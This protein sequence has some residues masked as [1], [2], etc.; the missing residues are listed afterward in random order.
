MK[1]A[2][3]LRKSRDEENEGKEKVLERHEKQLVD[4]C[5]RNNHIVLDVFKEVVSGDTIDKRPG[6][7]KLLRNVST[8]LYEGVV[9]MDIDRLS[10]GSQIDQ[11]E[12]LE[13]FKKSGTKILTLNKVYDLKNEDIDEEFFEF[14]LFMSRREYKI[15]KK[16]MQRG[17]KQALKD[18]YFTGGICPLGYDKKK[19]GR[20]FVLVP[21]KDAETVKE[22]FRR[23]LEG[24]KL[25]SIARHLNN[26]GIRSYMDKEFSGYMVKNILTNK[27]YAGFIRSKKDNIYYTGKHAPIISLE[28]YE[29]AQ[30]MLSATTS[31][32]NAFKGLVNPLAGVL[33]C[34]ICG[35]VMQVAS[36]GN[37]YY[38]CKTIDCPTTGASVEKVE[39]ALLSELKEELASFNYYVDNYET[40]SED[41]KEAAE[42]E[43]KKLISE[44][45]K[46][47]AMAN[48]ACELLEQGIYT[49]E[50]Y[51]ERVN[52]LDQ[53][54]KGLNDRVIE[55]Q[56]ASYEDNSI[57]QAIPKLS[58]VLECYPSLSP[59]EKNRLIKS[60]VK[61]IDYHKTV[62]TRQL[63]DIKLDIYLKI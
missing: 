56:S 26:S 7:K 14:A 49:K 58:E 59:K 12:I 29:K 30:A 28:D 54:L 9:C 21:N 2:I 1:V 4:Y 53:E 24:E 37:R 44:I 13:T 38:F 52:I 6:V 51:L 23:Y 41:K 48:R 62:K 45:D 36:S 27:T 17:K 63:S 20:G 8:G 3:Y 40:I 47:Q 25:T 33:R 5:R 16:R 10:R 60:I 35:K 11:V 43:L 50:K 39:K 15:I 32:E 18:G 61:R 34:G 19:I 42:K 22:I 57:K 31:K 46:R 55:L